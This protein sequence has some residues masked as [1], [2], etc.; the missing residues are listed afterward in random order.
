MAFEYINDLR[1]WEDADILLIAVTNNGTAYIRDLSKQFI[2]DDPKPVLDAIAEAESMVR[3]TP[4]LQGIAIHL[5]EGAKW[6]D[7]WGTLIPKRD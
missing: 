7:E 4:W 5:M 2:P 1:D 6:N 3:N